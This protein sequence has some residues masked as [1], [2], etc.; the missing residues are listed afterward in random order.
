MASPL[1]P[2]PPLR[3]RLAE[4]HSWAEASEAAVVPAAACGPS[5]WYQRGL[6]R[7]QRQPPQQ[8]HW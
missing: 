6:P 7:Q 2:K 8:P 1:P 5:P 4:K 3:H